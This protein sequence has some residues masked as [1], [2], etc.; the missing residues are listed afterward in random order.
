MSIFASVS[1]TR[2]H[3]FASGRRLPPPVRERNV[4]PLERNQWGDRAVLVAEILDRCSR[5]LERNLHSFNGTDP[6]HLMKRQA[7]VMGTTLESM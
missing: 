2:V 7:M 6:L 3:F 5:T 4:R 1:R